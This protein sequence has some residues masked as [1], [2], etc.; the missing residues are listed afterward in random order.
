MN[1]YSKSSDT[2]QTRALLLERLNFRYPNNT[3]EVEEDN[4]II[5]RLPSA[6]VDTEFVISLY[7][8]YGI[9]GCNGLDNESMG[10]VRELQVEVDD[11]Y[12]HYV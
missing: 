7:E 6:T 11:I 8:D 12:L 4:T 5:V 2:S 1:M 9:V 10:L 3:T